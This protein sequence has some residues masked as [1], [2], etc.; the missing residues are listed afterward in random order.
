MEKWKD[1]IVTKHL[2]FHWM[3]VVLIIWVS[4]AA[5]VL[6]HYNFPKIKAPDKIVA[7]KYRFHH[8]CLDGTDVEYIATAKLNAMVVCNELPIEPT[9][10]E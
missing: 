8:K 7:Q 10:V 9:E 5:G 2:V 4:F 3:T 1:W 6:A